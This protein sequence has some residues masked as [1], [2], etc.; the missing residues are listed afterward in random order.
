MS[1]ESKP[2][3]WR[4]KT[5]EKDQVGAGSRVYIYGCYFP[6]TDLLITDMGVRRTGEPQ[7]EG[8][9]WLDPKEGEDNVPAEV[10]GG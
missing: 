10:D 4:I 6:G 2:R 9:E 1:R 5:P 7:W 8:I 3:R